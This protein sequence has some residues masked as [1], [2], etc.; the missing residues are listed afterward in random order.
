MEQTLRTDQTS[1]DSPLALETIDSP[2]PEIERPAPSQPHSFKGTLI[3]AWI[4]THCQGS[5]FY[6]NQ[7]AESIV[8]IPDVDTF[9]QFEEAVDSLIQ[10]LSYRGKNVTLI[11][12]NQAIDTASIALPPVRGGQQKAF[13]REKARRIEAE[14][15]AI[16]W[17]SQSVAKSKVGAKALLYSIPKDRIHE[18][19]RLFAKR[20]ITLGRAIPLSSLFPIAGKSLIKD[21]TGLSILV[22]PLGK[23][24][25]IIVLDETS[26]LVFIRD[27]ALRRSTDIHR[28]AVEL[29]RC[30]LFTRQQYGKPVEQ[31]VLL[32]SQFELT[33]PLLKGV[34]G[35]DAPLSWRSLDEGHW[36]QH[37]HHKRCLNLAKEHITQDRN[38][39]WKQTAIFACSIALATLSVLQGLVL[40]SEEQQIQA[41]ARSL[42]VQESN[43]IQSLEQLNERQSKI[44]RYA[45]FAAATSRYGRIPV[46]SAFLNLLATELPPQIW[47]S[48]L[49]IEWI[50]SNKHWTFALTLQSELSHRAKEQATERLQEV[51]RNAP[52]GISDI[53]SD[54][55]SARQVYSNNKSSN[56]TRAITLKGIIG[57]A[58]WTNE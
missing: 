27:L 47:I 31:I 48:E 55:S 53:V 12:D 29:N 42:I 19:D 17:E 25:K 3:V 38:R 16:I 13:I 10:S 24:V 54:S 2:Q 49:S 46:E 6:Q 33:F 51:L 56:A 52:L 8:D 15:G 21:S 30:L 11:A 32:G 28:I 41:Q 37:A 23:G 26:Q 9:E 1:E 22:A 40:K 5:V 45:S 7:L 58:G 39:V 57:K 14:S 43:M 44:D 35:Q 20:K 4:G 34:L 50:E 18:I 36:L